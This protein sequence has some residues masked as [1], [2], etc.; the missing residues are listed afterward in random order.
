[1]ATLRCTRVL[2]GVLACIMDG[3]GV[4]Q[5]HFEGHEPHVPSFP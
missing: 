3:A 1:M 5:A 2:A 4:Q